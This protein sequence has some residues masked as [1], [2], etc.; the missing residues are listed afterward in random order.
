MTA[1]YSAAAGSVA[2]PSSSATRRS[3]GRTTVLPSTT[4]IAGQ[5]S[6]AGAGRPSSS[7]ASGASGESHLKRDLVAVEEAAQLGAGGIEA[8]PDDDRARRRR[9]G[10]E[11]CSP[12]G[13]DMRS[14]ASLPTSFATSGAP[15]R[16]RGSRAARSAARAT[17]RRGAEAD[18][19]DRPERDRHLA[20]ELAG[21]ALADDA[22]D[23]V[24]ELDRLDRA[25]RGRR[26]APA[27]RPRAR[28][29]RPARA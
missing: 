7:A 8:V 2:R 28:R 4:R 29:T 23:A 6:S 24:D 18:R 5:S 16:R 20:E 10:G 13:P 22:L 21:V 3:V 12:R 15:R 19:E 9:V 27:R 25:A 26:T 17:A 14:A 11:P 1:S